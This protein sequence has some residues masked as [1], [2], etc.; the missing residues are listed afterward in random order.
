MA[1]FTDGIWSIYITLITIAG[2]FGCAVLLWAQSSVKILPDNEDGKVG[3]TGHSW[4]DGLEELNN[5]MPRWWLWLFVLTIVF[6][7]AYLY[8]YPGLGT[9]AGKLGWQSESQYRNEVMTA[10]AIHG[11]QFDAYLRQDLKSVAADSHARAIGERLFLTYCAQCHGSDAGGSKGFP[12]LTDRDWLYGGT[13]EAIKTSILNGRRGMMPPM[14]AAVGS[15]REINEVA[16]YVRNL[17]GLSADPVKKV[18]GQAKF[19][20]ACAACHG[21]AGTGNTALGA[22]N[23]T[24]KIWLHG[25][26]ADSIMET[27]RKGRSSVMPEFKSFLGEAKVHVLAAYVWSLSA[28]E[29]TLASPVVPQ[30]VTQKAVSAAP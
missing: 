1:D 18:T 11:P 22:P 3:T 29:A 15:E 7:L 4:D 26:S 30:L 10:E 8:L 2:I 13:P 20:V 17:S 25:G 9:Y 21:A 14:G 12:N 6:G 27:I 16:H 5:P 19:A 23:L 28:D 24:D